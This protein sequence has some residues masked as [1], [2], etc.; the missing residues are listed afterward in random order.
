MK[1][2]K[3]YHRVDKASNYSQNL[4]DNAGIKADI[5]DSVSCLAGEDAA[6]SI[7][8]KLD[9]LDVTID[10]RLVVTQKIIDSLRE[11]TVYAARLGYD[12][13]YGFTEK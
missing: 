8:Y 6:A 3:A 5:R 11:E 1:K 7:M 10:Q 9:T 12:P 13:L 2:Y 4:F